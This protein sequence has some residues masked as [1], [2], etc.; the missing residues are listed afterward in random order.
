[1]SLKKHTINKKLLHDTNKLQPN[2]LYISAHV[3]LKGRHEL[4]VK[5]I[6]ASNLIVEGGRIWTLE[7]F[8]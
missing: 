8:I 4:L 3:I 1:M 7:V 2:L 5:K 6:L